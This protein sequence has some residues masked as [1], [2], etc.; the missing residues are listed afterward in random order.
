LIIARGECE[1]GTAWGRVS[2]RLWPPG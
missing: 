1:R 2:G